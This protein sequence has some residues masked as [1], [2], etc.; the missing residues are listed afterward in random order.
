[1]D[2]FTREQRSEVMRRIK[3]TDTQPELIVRRMLHRAG[4]RYRL[5]VKTLPG[6]PDLVLPR[7]KTVIFVHGCFWHGHT[8]CKG[9]HRPKS[10]TGYWNQKIER[11]VQRGAIHIQELRNSGWKCIIVWECEIKNKAN[12]EQRLVAEL[13]NDQ[14]E[15]AIIGTSC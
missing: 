14:T 9:G 15:P 11:N 10:N 6:K 2:T 5:H 7:Y 13:T 8:A 3:G 1:M 4:F 12:L